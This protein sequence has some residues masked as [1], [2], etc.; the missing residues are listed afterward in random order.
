MSTFI[1]PDILIIDE[2]LS[3]GDVFFAEK[4][5]KR[6]KQ[7]ANKGRVVL[8]VS[9]SLTSIVDMCNRCIWLDKGRLVL[10]GDPKE[11]TD[12]YLASVERAD[13]AELAAKFD[14]L[15]ADEVRPGTGAIA[16][17]G[18]SQDSAALAT[19]ARAFLPLRVTID[20]R[21]S[22]QAP[23]PDLELAITRVDGRRIFRKRLSQAVPGS[24]PRGE[25]R[26]TIDLDPFLLGV[27]LY[28]L[29]AALFDASGPIAR[30]HRVVQVT[31]DEGQ[32]GGTPLLFLPPIITSTRIETA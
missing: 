24:A 11:V 32:F 25:A 16:D 28:R 1:N 14:P 4:A 26:I 2:T 20:V 31:D 13:E 29:D 21:V 15:E 6:I 12:A 30:H 22:Y 7:I 18:L 3:V 8:L 9:H 5:A 17:I 19:T 23:D 27:G 10:D